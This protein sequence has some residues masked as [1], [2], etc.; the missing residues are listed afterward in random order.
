MDRRNPVG[1]A[2]HERWDENLG[3]SAQR[4][5]VYHDH[6]TL[7]FRRRKLT[8]QHSVCGQTQSCRECSAREIGREPWFERTAQRRVSRPPHPKFP[9]EETYSSAQRLWADAI[10]SGVLCTRDGTRTLFER[11]AQR[12]VSRPP[13]PSFRRRKL[14]H[15]HSVCGQTQSCRECS[16]REMDENLSSSAQHSV[17]ITTTSPKFPEEETY[18]SAQRLWADAILSGVLCTR[19]GREP[20]F[21]RIAQANQNTAKPLSLR[22]SQPLSYRA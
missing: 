4:S 12:R 19:V 16:A 7:S 5:V 3:S 22:H 14:T 21:E 2:L 1:S 10:L 15:Q 18:S 11:T 13:H 8:H 9:E 17:V 20:W 6:L